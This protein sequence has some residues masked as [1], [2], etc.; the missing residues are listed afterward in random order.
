MLTE[1]AVGQRTLFGGPGNDT[2]SGASS[3][4]GEAGDDTLVHPA[5]GGSGFLHG[6]D[7]ADRLADRAG[8]RSS[9]QGEAGPDSISGGAGDDALFGGAGDDRHR[10]RSGE[11]V[12]LRRGRQRLITGGWGRYQRRDGR[13]TCRRGRAGRQRFVRW[14]SRKRHRQLRR[15][16]QPQPR[17]GAVLSASGFGNDGEPGEGDTTDAENLRGRP[18][19]QHRHRR[20]RPNRLE[21]GPSFDIVTSIDG[22][23][24]ND[25]IIGHSAAGTDVC[26][27]DAGPP[28]DAVHCP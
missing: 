13:R 2:L 27:G 26:Q 23:G 17:H 7:G 24:G 21:G 22:I 9:L 25:V 6:G 16:R 1:H 18:R 14:R 19:P 4:F 11:R 5:G 28:P 3:L 10:R 12:H 15:A 20:R 8:V